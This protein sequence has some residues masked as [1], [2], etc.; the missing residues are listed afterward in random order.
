MII[1]RRTMLTLTAG[2]A[3]A[4]MA[5]TSL[6]RA[7]SGDKIKIGYSQCTLNH[8][9]RVAQTDGNR[10]YCEKNYPDVQLIVTDGN[11]DSGKQVSDIESLLTQDIKVLMVA[12]LTAAALTPIVKQAMQSGIP[13]VALDR[14]V[15][16]K[17]TCHIGAKNTPIG[18]AAAALLAKKLGGKGAIIELQGTAGASATVDRNKG[19]VDQLAKTPD[20]KIVASQNCDYTRDKAVKFMED[21]VQRFGEGA[22]QAVYAHNDEMA[23][24]AIQ[25]LEGAGRL[26]GVQ[27]IGIDGQ[28]NAINA[29]AAG[30]LTAT[31]TYP[32]VAPEGIQYA[33]K[34]AKG[35]T[36]P[37][38]VVLESVAITAENAKDM[39]GKGF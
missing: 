37:A 16:T 22:I 10:I 13:V 20:L 24:G 39:I 7:A 12:P 19:F 17:V 36:V 25:V 32:Y 5:G 23:L 8:P 6:V 4:S 18:A 35:E 30:K 28:N 14:E 1:T 34:I 31:F 38:E 15:N 3:G 11:N 33:Y 26:K 21:M 9:W 2:F 27:V 29:V